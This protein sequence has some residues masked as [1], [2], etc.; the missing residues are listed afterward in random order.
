MATSDSTSWR[1]KLR[2]SVRSLLVL[3]LVIGGWLGWTVRNAKIQREAVAAIRLAGGTVT[4]HWDKRRTRSASPFAKPWWPKWLVKQLG[5]DYFGH[6]VDVALTSNGRKGEEHWIPIKQLALT[7]VAALDQLE[8]IALSG[9]FVRDEDLACLG[10]LSK[11]EGL[12]LENTS[13]SD[14]GL[15]HLARLAALQRLELGANKVTDDGLKH[16]AGLTKLRFLSLAD[17]RITGVGLEHLT[18][19]PELRHLV[20]AHNPIDDAGLAHL[21]GLTRLTNLDLSATQV[22]DAGL[23]HISVISSIKSVDLKWTAV[24]KTGLKDLNSARPGLR[25]DTGPWMIV[26]P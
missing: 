17:N 21:T 26:G 24:T 7:R 1:R 3:V 2:L 9:S 10:T 6:A 15:S 4:Y 23:A 16:L 11:L 13:V 14:V 8:N 5:V 22:T 18:E 25:C 12:S 19:L 20:L